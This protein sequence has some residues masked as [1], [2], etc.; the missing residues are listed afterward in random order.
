MYV[1]MQLLCDLYRLMWH[2]QTEIEQWT[3]GRTDDWTSSHPIIGHL[4]DW[5][6]GM[7]L[8]DIGGGAVAVADSSFCC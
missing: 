3:G 8:D 7:M 5:V 2:Y 6:I 1:R 4:L